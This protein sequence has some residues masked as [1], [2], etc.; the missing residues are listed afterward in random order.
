MA[1]PSAFQPALQLLYP[2][3]NRATEPWHQ[4]SATEALFGCPPILLIHSPKSKASAEIK[5]EKN[6]HNHAATDQ[7]TA[8]F[9][10]LTSDR[11]RRLSKVLADA[12]Q[13]VNSP[14]VLKALSF[15]GNK[16]AV[17][18]NVRVWRARWRVGKIEWDLR[19]R[20][21]SKK[22][23]KQVSG[24]ANRRVRTPVGTRALVMHAL[25]ILRR[26]LIGAALFAV[27]C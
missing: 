10:P 24:W 16:A 4:F 14:L 27:H 5:H 8:H 26:S 7:P 1:N 23:S 17:V 12:R 13:S 25:Q 19:D 21:C 18:L 11:H 2:S 6:T 15:F 3:G 20:A 22:L 9:R